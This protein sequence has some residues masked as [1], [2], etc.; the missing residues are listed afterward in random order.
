MNG[1]NRVPKSKSTLRMLAS[2]D[3][4]GETQIIDP[5]APPTL[6]HTAASQVVDK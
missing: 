1:I 6:Q 3:N 2:Q 5:D 4:R